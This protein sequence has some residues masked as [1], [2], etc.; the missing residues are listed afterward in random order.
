MSTEKQ[1]SK[2]EALSGQSSV[3]RWLGQ[4]V[5][6]QPFHE[7]DKIFGLEILVELAKKGLIV[8]SQAHV[9][10]SSRFITTARPSKRYVELSDKGWMEYEC[11]VA[12]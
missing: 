4:S 12:V 5:F 8:R 6:P 1:D 9:S 2:Q 10:F 7:L 11:L 3:I